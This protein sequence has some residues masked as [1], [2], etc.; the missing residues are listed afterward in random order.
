MP[1]LVASGSLHHLAMKIAEKLIRRL[2][3]AGGAA[4]THQIAFTR[5]ERR[6]L[7]SLLEARKIIRVGYGCY[8]MA[9]TP[10]PIQLARLTNA[11]LTCVSAVA[12]AGLRTLHTPR[13]IHLALD[14]NRGLTLPRK[15]VEW[16]V[17]HREPRSWGNAINAAP[18][19]KAATLNNAAPLGLSHFD[20]V[21]NL[22]PPAGLLAPWPAV[23]ARV[24]VCQPLVEAVIAI[25]SGLNTGVVQKEEIL[26]LL[27]PHKHQRAIEAVGLASPTSQSVLESLARLEL[28]S[29]GL[30]VE[31]QTYVDEVGYVD[32]LVEDVVAVE[33]DGFEY[34]R[35]RVQFSR[36]RFRDRQLRMM[37]YEVLRYAYDEVI[38]SPE[39]VVAD[40]RKILNS[41]KIRLAPPAEV[42]LQQQP[43]LAAR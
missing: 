8:A 38:N 10:V 34:H 16:S 21:P 22:N 1:F 42:Q 12:F 43:S 23:F 5:H 30:K 36:D 18:I 17:I 32:L 25:D 19:K 9:D 39:L 3:M 29:E 37:G 13:H 28:V 41:R 40:V 35:D 15:F 24:A 11:K 4:R 6:V 26:R 14:S 31:P 7:K 2:T 27:R 20:A 33:L